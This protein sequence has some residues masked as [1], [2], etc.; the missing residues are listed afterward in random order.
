[1]VLFGEQLA[2]GYGHWLAGS[3]ESVQCRTTHRGWFGS[4]RQFREF[5][6]HD[7]LNRYVRRDRRQRQ[8][9]LVQSGDAC[10]RGNRRTYECNLLFGEGHLWI[11]LWM[12]Q[13]YG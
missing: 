8:S 1:M 2:D 13:K 4:G 6:G 9:Y 10:G 11:G 5:G 3:Q 12:N 7:R